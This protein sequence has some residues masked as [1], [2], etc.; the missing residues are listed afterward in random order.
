MQNT[1]LAKSGVEVLGPLTGVRK[2]IESFYAS[3]SPHT[4]RNYGND[5]RDFSAFRQNGENVGGTCEEFI[6]LA[7]GDANLVA[8]DWRSD[9]I[10]RKLSS[11]TINRRLSA[12]RSLIALA[13]RIGQVGWKLSV[14]NVKHES[15][16]DT[17]GPTKE[18]FRSMLIAAQRNPNQS[19]A[20][21]DVAI[22]RI[23]FADALRRS[24][25]YSLDLEHFDLSRGTVSILGKGRSGRELLS[26]PPKALAAITAW[27]ETRGRDEGPLFP[28][29][30]RGAKWKGGRLT[31]N[32]FYKI[33]VNIGK[34]A[35]V[36]VRP[37][38]LRH[39][40]ITAAA[41][42]SSDPYAVQEFAR[43][44]DLK[45]TMLYVHRSKNVQ[46]AVASQVEED[47]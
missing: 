2:L 19:K 22:L 10:R 7:H 47:V 30:H 36:K 12:L 1:Q 41:T 34:L 46:G 16:R 37:H 28:S 42:Q 13:N 3:L 11:G 45:T 25:V 38:G 24:E 15:Y 39:A 35:G 5:L 6:R 20:A 26:I 44:K 9:M 21:R 18:Q 29:M 33:V 31:P 17:S 4:R 40:G 14:D 27:V 32:G 23:C 8:L 43:H